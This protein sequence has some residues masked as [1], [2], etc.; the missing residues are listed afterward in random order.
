MVERGEMQFL[1]QL[2]DALGKAIIRLEYDYNKKDYESYART[3]K[4]ILNVQRKISEV[5]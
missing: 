1:G 4:F 5:L 3:R 2:I